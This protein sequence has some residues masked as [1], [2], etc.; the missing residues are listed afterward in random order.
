[1]TTEKQAPRRLTIL[2]STGSIGQN[3]LDVIAHLGGRD[4]FEGKALT[5]NGNIALLAE[6][7]QAVGASLAVTANDEHYAALKEALAGSGIAVAAGRG[8]LT[9]AAEI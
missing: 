7:A 5:G 9:E 3:T 2:G 1:M 8:G 4:A 6:Q